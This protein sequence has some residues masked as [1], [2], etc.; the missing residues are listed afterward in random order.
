MCVHMQ[1][2]ARLGGRVDVRQVRA[3]ALRADNVVQAAGRPRTPVVS[4]LKIGSKRITGA[5][6]GHSARAASRE[7]TI[8][9]RKQRLC[10]RTLPP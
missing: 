2:G 3:H 1:D 5:K 9:A 10:L 8:C 4:R 7:V 6:P